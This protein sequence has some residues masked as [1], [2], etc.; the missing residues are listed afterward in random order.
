MTGIK[1][2]SDALEAHGFVTSFMTNHR[3]AIYCE[4][5]AGGCGVGAGPVGSRMRGGGKRRKT[6][7]GVDYGS[8]LMLS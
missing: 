6:T 3:D 4:E 7:G 1:T 2:D 8:F 5:G